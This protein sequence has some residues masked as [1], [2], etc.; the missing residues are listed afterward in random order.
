M[1]ARRLA[2]S[3]AGTRDQPDW[4]LR[5]W[6]LGLVEWTVLLSLVWFGFAQCVAGCALWRPGV[7]RPACQFSFAQFRFVSFNICRPAACSPWRK[8]RRLGSCGAVRLAC[9]MLRRAPSSHGAARVC[10]CKYACIDKCV[11][12]R[13]CVCV[14]ARAGG[15][16]NEHDGS[17]H[18]G[19]C[20]QCTGLP[21]SPP[22]SLPLSLSLSHSH[23][24]PSNTRPVLSS[25]SSRSRPPPTPATQVR[26]LKISGP[27][28]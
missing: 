3:Q 4:R 26:A 23:S 8:R 1:Q 15:L 16:Y 6:W 25:T 12:A 18:V 5:L 20:F 14:R 27:P 19:H 7:E 17:D 9:G 28:H 22:L 21:L 24:R 13:V 11:C 2:G 10:T